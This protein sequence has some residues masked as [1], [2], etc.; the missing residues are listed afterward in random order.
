MQVEAVFAPTRRWYVVLVEP[1]AEA[2]VAERAGELGFEVY[3]PRSRRPA[4][5]APSRKA[6]ALKEI[7]RPALPGY[8]F[9]ALPIA[10][11]RFDLFQ[12]GNW[13]PSRN[14]PIDDPD[15][16]PWVEPEV[17]PIFGARGFIANSDGPM[18]LDPDEIAKL[19]KR[20]AAGDF[21]TIART[22]DGKHVIPKWIKQG[23]RIEFSD[24]PFTGLHGAI[25]KP[26]GGGLVDVWAQ[27]FAST[28][29][30]TCPIDWLRKAA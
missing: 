2:K 23:V 25:S 30:L 20:E 4:I 13:T 1:S 8:V 27:L 7:E 9:V 15:A 3:F 10:N 24:G 16:P 6:P 21:D 22:P 5:V 28:R 12:G 18:F 29:L 17:A 14:K 26:L 11:P 19:R